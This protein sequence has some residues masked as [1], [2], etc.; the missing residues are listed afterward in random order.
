[1]RIGSKRLLVQLGFFIFFNAAFLGLPLLPLLL[2]VFECYAMPGKTVLCNFGV[3]QRNLSFDLEV[4]PA[5]PLASVAM[6]IVVGAIVG[7]AMCG[8]ACPLGFVQDIFT[9]IAHLLKMKQK[10]LSE[11]LRHFLTGVKYMVLLATLAIVASVGITYVISRLLG[12]KYA[13]SLGICGRAPYCV[14]CPVPVFFVTVPSLLNALFTGGTLPQMPLT[15]YIGLSAFMVFVV[16]SLITK[17]FWCRYLCPLGALM[18]LFNK[19]SLLHIKKRKHDCTTFCKGHQKECDDSCPM[20][21]NI[22]RQEEL[23]SNSE[24]I[25]CY[26]CSEPCPKKAIECRLG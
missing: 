16:L 13:F 23:S 18:S 4:F 12:Y 7:R 10:E 14:I 15:F 21:I 24:C 19:L 22:S 17:R 3:L 5:F 11:K 9:S 25:L 6:F 26:N 1:L 20:G 2:P 8:W